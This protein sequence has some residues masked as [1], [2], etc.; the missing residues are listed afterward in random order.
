M[1][2]R[3]VIAVSGLQ[4][5]AIP[6]E[7]EAR[8]VSKRIAES[9]FDADQVAR[10]L[11]KRI[12]G[13]LNAEDRADWKFVQELSTSVPYDLE[14]AT[15]L[16]YKGLCSFRREIEGLLEGLKNDPDFAA[17]DVNELCDGYGST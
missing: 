2:S 1:L 13:A 9:L 5:S 4:W 3:D 7:R 12:A 15:R 11:D 10:Y 6:I 16:I 14:S 17:I 8:T